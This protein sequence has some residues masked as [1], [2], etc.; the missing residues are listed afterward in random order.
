MAGDR[1]ATSR[2]A[3]SVKEDAYH[4]SI[5][6][7]QIQDRPGDLAQGPLFRIDAISCLAPSLP[8]YDFAEL[9]ARCRKVGPWRDGTAALPWKRRAARPP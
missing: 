5:S 6:I 9:Q 4:S 2:L 3:G 8:C 7:T 1:P